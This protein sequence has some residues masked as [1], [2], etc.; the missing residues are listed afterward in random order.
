M[1]LMEWIEN[2]LKIYENINYY[3]LMASVLSCLNEVCEQQIL[4]RS[5]G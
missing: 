4:C 1:R 3:D 2:Y 5:K